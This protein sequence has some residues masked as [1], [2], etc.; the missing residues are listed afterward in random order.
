MKYERFGIGSG[1]SHWQRMRNTK[2]DIY[3][4]TSASRQ[5]QFTRL[6]SRCRSTSR[7]EGEKTPPINE[8]ATFADNFVSSLELKMELEMK[9][10]GHGTTFTQEMLLVFVAHSSSRLF[11]DRQGLTTARRERKSSRLSEGDL[12][13]TYLKWK[14]GS[15]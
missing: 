11:R 12:K 5:R 15:T 3:G 9:T 2:T 14:K 10:L 8:P 13:P 7:A 6:R 4:F 1:T